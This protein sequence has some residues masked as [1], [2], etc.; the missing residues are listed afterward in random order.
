MDAAINLML[1]SSGSGATFLGEDAVGWR[2]ALIAA[3]VAAVAYEATLALLRRLRP[4]ARWVTLQVPY[5]V[6]LIGWLTVSNKAWHAMHDEWRGALWDVLLDDERSPVV[7]WFQ[8]MRFSLSLV[9][10]GAARTAWE[11]K[12]PAAFACLIPAN[13]LH[14]GYVWRKM[15]MLRLILPTTLLVSVYTEG[16]I[17]VGVLATPIVAMLSWVPVIGYVWR[18]VRAQHRD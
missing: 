3:V 1:A 8:G 5:F 18:D 9:F 14:R 2:T 10:S 17:W 6:L 16:S 13:D 4:A 11:L 15:Q 7:N 12:H